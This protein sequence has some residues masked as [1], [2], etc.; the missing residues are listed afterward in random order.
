M[1]FLQE[2]HSIRMREFCS[3]ACCLSARH[4]ECECN[5]REGSRWL[6]MGGARAKRTGHGDRPVV[7]RN[8]QVSSRNFASQL[9]V[10]IALTPC[11]QGSTGGLS[12]SVCLMSF[13]ACWTA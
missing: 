12:A 1:W 9:A 3:F 8:R 4:P 6:A 2:I 5:E 13:D 11:H 7:G 10:T